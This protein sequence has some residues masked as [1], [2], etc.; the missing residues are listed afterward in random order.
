M[1][2]AGRLSEFR[3]V[4]G[5]SRP[6][7]AQ[8]LNVSTGTITRWER[9]LTFPRPALLQRVETILEAD[10]MEVRLRLEGAAERH[11]QRGQQPGRKFTVRVNG[12]EVPI[13]PPSYVVNGPPDQVPFFEELYRLQSDAAAGRPAREMV[14]RLSA[15]DS[16]PTLS[17]RTAQAELE[18][19]STTRRSWDSNYGPHGWHRYIGRFPPHLVRAA[20]N[21]FGITRDDLVV[22]P[23]LGSGTT[24]VET[25]LLGLSGLGIEIS[26]LSAMIARTKAE[27]PT[28]TAHLESL[29]K[30]FTAAYNEGWTRWHHL[31]LE[32]APHM[33]LL[34]RRGNGIPYFANIERWFTPEALLG[35][36]LTVEWL[37]KLHG[38]DRDFFSTALS[39]AM[40]SIGNLDVDVVRAEYR[41]EPR[42]NV[43]VGKLVNARLRRMINDIGMSVA[44]HSDLYVGS[45]GTE[46]VQGNALTTELAPGSVRA[47]ITSPPY[48]VESLSY[49]RTHLLSYRALM[50]ILGHDP[51]ETAEGVVGSEYLGPV[52][53]IEYAEA[54]AVSSTCSNFFAPRLADRESALWSRTMMMLHFFEDMVTTARKMSEWLVPQGRVAFVIGNKRLGEDIIPTHSIVED[55]FAKHGLA[56]DTS[57]A[58]KLKTNNS[59]S[60]VPWQDRI[61]QEEHIML[62][63]RA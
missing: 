12:E 13:T 53:E 18:S 59:N 21:H 34:Q 22:D 45:K 48:G 49:L 36:S 23:F 62:F 19:P 46:V 28:D 58:H 1:S 25:R 26:P 9:E 3:R 50:P 63:T 16:V 20:L 27:W 15:V 37:S 17:I 41:K 61:I 30:Q 31:T 6:D 29:Q 10:S 56:L 52:E 35:V 51:Y 54:M 47:V 57:I 4:H 43:N 8:I 32:D 11:R 38:Y 33:Q 14:R 60:E 39:S 5:L 7:A 2:L 24:L 55:I 44:T 42:C 40:R